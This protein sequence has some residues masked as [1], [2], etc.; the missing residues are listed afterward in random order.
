MEPCD[1]VNVKHQYRPGVY[2]LTQAVIREPDGYQQQ[3]PNWLLNAADCKFIEC[4]VEEH[5]AFFLD[6]IQKELYNKSRKIPSMGTVHIELPAR[7]LFLFNKA[8][9]S[10]VRKSLVAKY[11]WMSKWLHVTAHYFVFTGD[12]PFLITAA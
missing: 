11:T 3:G 6:E 9:V 8:S 10:N 12:S 2:H 1:H 7:L 4:L 5:P